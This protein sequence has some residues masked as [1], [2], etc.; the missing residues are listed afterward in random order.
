MGIKNY[1]ELKQAV[2]LWIDREDLGVS[3][4]TIGDNSMTMIETFISLAERKI[5]RGVSEHLKTPAN[6]KIG[7]PTITE[8]LSEI[9]LPPDLLG[10]SNILV[11]GV[12]YEYLPYT[13]FVRKYPPIIA[14][15][16][17]D[18][19][20]NIQ[21][22][23]QYCGNHFTRKLN[24]VL[25]SKKLKSLGDDSYGNPVYPEVQIYYW[26]DL[27]GMNDDDETNE[28]LRIAPDLYLFGALVEAEGYLVNDPRIP[29][30][31]QKFDQA[32]QRLVSFSHQAD[33]SS[34]P[35]VMGG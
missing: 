15:F 5:F 21:D 23:A 24:K 16:E 22:R 13:N 29:V 9:V 10:I 20:N 12:P 14:P 26:A 25:F 8:E 2:K 28:V 18:T 3:G 19:P 35:L 11:Q 32:Y 6:E 34:G 31:Q 1:G 33:Y 17:E 27:S 7:I 30:W 4:P